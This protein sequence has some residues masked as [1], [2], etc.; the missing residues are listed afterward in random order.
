M[1]C[2]IHFHMEGFE[3]LGQETVSHLLLIRRGCLQTSPIVLELNL[4]SVV[5]TV[6][7]NPGTIFSIY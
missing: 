4:I 1:G 3:E 2:D 7:I 6:T 5:V